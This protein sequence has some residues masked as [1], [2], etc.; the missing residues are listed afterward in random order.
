MR[1]CVRVSSITIYHVPRE[2]LSIAAILQTH[3]LVVT[4]AVKIARES[5][6]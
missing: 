6:G 2:A 5:R 1:E 3:A 4:F